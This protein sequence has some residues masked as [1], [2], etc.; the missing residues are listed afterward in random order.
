MHPLPD[1]PT[2]QGFILSPRL[3]GELL[4]NLG[5]ALSL[6]EDLL[7]PDARTTLEGLRAQLWQQAFS[8]A[9]PRPQV[10]EDQEHGALVVAMCI[11]AGFSH[12]PVDGPTYAQR[13]R[14]S[15]AHCLAE[16]TGPHS[17]DDL[18]AWDREEREYAELLLGKHQE[19]EAGA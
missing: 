19:Q 9:A 3:A 4:P 17:A 2:A 13:L 1:P 8:L 18:A 10:L 6:A 15:A 7:S 5:T 11:V 16:L 14:R 12:I